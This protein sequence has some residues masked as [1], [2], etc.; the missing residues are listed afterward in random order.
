MANVIEII[1]KQSGQGNAI[2]TTVKELG[3]LDKAASSSIG[4]L[5]RFGG[6]LTGMLTV[7]GG[8]VAANIFGKLAEGISSIVSTGL[9]AVGSNQQLETSLK[10]LLT[11]NNMYAESTETLQVAVGNLAEMQAEAADKSD[12]LAF[13]QRKLTADIKT[14]NATIQEQRQRIIQMADGLDKIQQ[15]ARLEE[16]EIALEGMTRELG[17]TITEQGKLNN[18]T[19][20][21][22]TITKTSIKTVMSQADAF[23]LASAQTQDLLD[24]VSR[25]AV[26]SPFETETVENVTKYAIAAG[27]GV[28]ATK[29]F[30][31]AFLDLAGAVGITSES[32]GFAADQLFQVKKVG[33]LTEIDLRQLRRIGIDLSK[34]IGVEM[35]M[36]VEEFNAAAANSPEIF[37]E[38]FAAVTR[39]SQNTFA[40]T[41][42]EMAQSVKGLQSTISD[43]FV[44]GSRT[45]MR[46]LVDAVTPAISEIIG[47]I[48]DFALG[49]DLET[50]GQQIANQVMGGMK[51]V[52][53]IF[54][55]LTGGKGSV[56][57]FTGLREM[58]FD[59]ETAKL[60]TD[61]TRE[62]RRFFEAFQAGDIKGMAT[63]L[64]LDPALVDQA[65]LIITDIKT[66][67]NTEW[68]SRASTTSIMKLGTLIGIDPQTTATI[69]TTI[70]NITTGI[71]EALGKITGAYERFGAKGAA[72]SIL[73]QLGM[74]PE[75]I[76]NIQTTIDEIS[77]TITEGF[78]KISGAYE[79]F[80]VEGAVTSL[81]GQL[82]LDPETIGLIHTNLNNIISG[83]EDFSLS[84]SES[85]GRVM[86]A[87]DK[88]GFLAGLQALAGEILAG[89]PTF[90]TS[91][92]DAIAEHFR[93]NVPA[94]QEAMAEWGPK[95]WEWV[96]NIIDGAGT[97]LAGVL[98]AIT[99]WVN[100]P[101]AGTSLNSAGEGI[102]K[103]IVTGIGLLLENSGELSAVL[104]KLSAGLLAAVATI[105]ADLIIVGGQITA[106]I[107][108]GI[109]ESLGVD[110]QPATFS[111]L[112]T[113]LENIGKDIV[114]IAKELG[115]RIV[116]AINDA[117]VATV[118]SGMKFGQQLKELMEEA[119][120]ILAD[121]SK[122]LEIGEMAMEGLKKGIEKNAGI[123]LEHL[124]TLLGNF[125]NVFAGPQGL[126]SRSPS[127]TM[128]EIGS[129]A[130]RGLQIG[131]ENLAPQLNQ[132]MGKLSQGMIN[133]LMTGLTVQDPRFIHDFIDDLNMGGIGKAAGAGGGQWRNFRNIL[134]NEITAGM[135]GL[136][137]G[138]IDFMSKITEVANRFHFPPNLAREFAQAEGLVEHLT[139]TFS[140]MFQKLRIENLASAAGIASNFSGFAAAFAGMLESQIETFNKTQEEAAKLA[141]TNQ[142]LT[143]SYSE[144]QNKLAILQEELAKLTTGNGQNT[145]AI[146][147]LTE[148][149][150]FGERQLQIY[151][152]EL[153]KLTPDTLP[154]DKKKLAIDKLTETMDMQRQELEKLQ[155]QNEID[156][157]A[158]DK[159]TLAIAELTEQMVKNQEAITKN[160][161]AMKKHRQELER[162]AFAGF[163]S[164]ATQQE[165]LQSD[166]AMIELLQDFLGSGAEK[167]RIVG[168]ELGGVFAGSGLTSDI[169]HTQISAQEELNRLLAEQEERERMITQQK[170][171]QQKLDFLMQ[172][173]NL[174]KLISDRGLSPAN[175]LEGITLGLDAGVEDLLAATNR[176]VEAM[177]AQIDHDLGIASPSK[178]MFDKFKNQ[179]GGGMVRGLMAVK[180]LLSGVM[181]PMLSPLTG[182]DY[183]K[184]TNNYFNQTVNTRAEQSS[185]I[186]DFRTMQ[187]MAG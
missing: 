178:V 18:V 53:G 5:G 68:G 17:D 109:L 33:K 2:S 85:F 75:T 81:L 83:I 4:T 136:E 138:S 31:P 92:T 120:G 19:Q 24:F 152:E 52:G 177:V 15:V 16:M 46:P 155:S 48:S 82:G 131:A 107:I 66:A 74:D 159:K 72:I 21:Y 169:I 22:E 145:M 156:T 94:F 58:G 170:E 121:P 175:I 186:G 65:K 44:I 61:I 41:S 20:E 163:S 134:I 172:Q 13:K 95:F 57:A 90:L 150:G 148:S 174:V 73:G 51:T 101:E 45:F 132:S 49:G 157:L 38:L 3:G 118:K 54:E 123:V 160:E 47:K 12:D 130:I 116:N 93:T 30:I 161:E 28:D 37:D 29:E 146:E 153:A 125:L 144:Q 40:G 126:D 110:L 187:L 86:N 115:R 112:S 105:T 62:V 114:T 98:L 103:S 91:I 143:K 102:G 42:K 162:Q 182:G 59:T 168:E 180:P 179:V 64:G 55:V 43:I 185:V 124:K 176:V 79:R 164:F 39:F 137:S 129:D 10:S 167:L 1:I 127:R 69:L 158:V 122:W 108:S 34:V 78:D 99:A 32:L 14:Q 23:K 149:L 133:S 56:R 7:A 165:E 88:E 166:M 135:S 71:E 106:G 142:G 27:M 119:K 154:W 151:N 6:A 8:I 9:D 84:V 117:M 140:V 87:W 36:S 139:G 104:L 50:I 183:S 111:E 184:T 171:A 100:S 113:I 97:A 26:A 128:M 141:T 63:M 80:G 89:I 77:T 35:G 147:K 60:I 181:G 25:L 11:A 173:I 76:G 70:N 96:N 67:I